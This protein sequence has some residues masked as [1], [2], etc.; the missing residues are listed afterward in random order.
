MLRGSAAA[1]IDDKGRLKIPSQ[2][3]RDWE[4]GY[5]PDVFITS[6]HGDCAL[7]YP[8]AVWEGIEARLS[9]LPSTDPVKVK[10]LE[11]VNYFGQQL[12]LDAQGRVVIPQIL[13]ERA[14]M[15]GEVTVGGQLDHLRVESRSRVEARVAEQALTT[16]DLAHLSGK[17]I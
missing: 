15:N 14:Q 17:G 1:R 7:I 11:R 3:R 2:F 4:D 13:R 8:L 9:A 6:L 12:R 10:F 5:G 16:E